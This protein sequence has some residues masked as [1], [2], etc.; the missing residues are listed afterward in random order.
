[1][2]LEEMKELYVNAMQCEFRKTLEGDLFTVRLYDGFDNIW[3][4]V[5]KG[6]NLETALK[7]WLS[8]TENGTKNT[9]YN[10]I[11]YYAIFPANTRMLNSDDSE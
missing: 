5:L 9:N 10:H 2:T 3:I 11:D 8:Q 7:M 6:A 4:D 1:M